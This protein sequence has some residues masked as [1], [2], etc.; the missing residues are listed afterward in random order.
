MSYGVIKGMKFN[1]T[2]IKLLPTIGIGIFILLSIYA[3]TLY[4]G[5]SQV[6]SNTLGFD[7][8]NNFWCN[9]TSAKGLNGVDNPARPI[10]ILAMIILCSSMIIFFF[11]FAEF[12]EKNK[13]WNVLIKLA[14]VISMVCAVFIF[15]S[16]HDVMTTILSIFGVLGIVCIIR[17]LYMSKMTFFMISGIICMI[18]IGLNNYFYYDDALIY[19]LPVLQ[20][21]NFVLILSWTIGLNLIIMRGAEKHRSTL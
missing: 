12:F 4:P 18:L 13:T 21:I 2:L 7:W 16:Y 20:K 9:L 5:G 3:A 10:A 6:D 8:R 19:Y 17:A 14:G 1:K 15:T 11:L